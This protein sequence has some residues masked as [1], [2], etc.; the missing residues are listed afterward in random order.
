MSAVYSLGA[1]MPAIQ[2]TTG[3]SR[4]E[5]SSGPT[6]LTVA[7]I[8][9]GPAMGSVIDRV[10]SRLIALL[11][12]AA[13]CT[14]LACLS[15]VSRDIGGWWI[16]WSAL[17]IGYVAIKPTVWTAAVV[18]RFTAGR[19]L[20]LGVALSGTGICSSLAPITATLIEGK[21]GWQ[22]TYIWLAAGLAIVTLPLTWVFL[23][24][25]GNSDGEAGIRKPSGNLGTPARWATVR[26][27]RYLLMAAACFLST[28]PSAAL[29][30]HFVPLEIAQGMSPRAAAAVASLLG[31]ATIVGRVVTGLALD[32]VAGNIV[33]AVSGLL[34]VAAAA[35][36]LLATS[37]GGASAGAILLGLSVGAELGV[38]A[39]MIPRF[40]GLQ[41]FGF[42][43][44]VM[45]TILSAALGVGP[46]VAGYAYDVS[47]SYTGFLIAALPAFAAAAVCFFIVGDPQP[48][49]RSSG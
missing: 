2:A 41:H 13:F 46:L 18:R 24:R 42:V 30:V 45:S 10:G 29:I 14:A 34:A 39:Y 3:W 47:G 44:G 8:V 23:T 48:D 36:L 11:G 37:A 17:A 7:A 4:A 32:R 38:L 19:G 1:L 26:S 49:R 40:F 43:F 9:F 25:D 5:I 6:L 12:L 22:S 20:A 33:G 27:P 31:I 35:S 15:L 21:V 28:F 16:G